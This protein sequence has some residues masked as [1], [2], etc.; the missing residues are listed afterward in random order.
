[1]TSYSKKEL[2]LLI[3]IEND[4]YDILEKINQIMK[5]DVKWIFGTIIGHF[6]YC[7]IQRIILIS[8]K[9]DIIFFT[10][11]KKRKSLP[12]TISELENIRFT[13]EEIM[14]EILDDIFYERRFNFEDIELNINDIQI[15]NLQN[16]F[17]RK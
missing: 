16:F 5:E 12:I 17:Q 11:I 3:G 7:P 10:E 9:G 6:D 13:Y 4:K 15:K 2:N 8:S 1:M 14:E